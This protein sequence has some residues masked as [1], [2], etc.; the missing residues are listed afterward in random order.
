MAPRSTEGVH[1]TRAFEMGST[2]LSPGISVN[3]DV[4]LM[5]LKWCLHPDYSESAGVRLMLL[6][7]TVEDTQ[8]KQGTKR[9][10][11]KKVLVE[12]KGSCCGLVYRSLCFSIL[13]GTKYK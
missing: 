11:G 7:D 12:A 1:L 5:G 6:V 3:T 8:E 4:D 2:D 9:L 13:K 10:L